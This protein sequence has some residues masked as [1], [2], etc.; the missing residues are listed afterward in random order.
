[1]R[2]ENTKT[3][4]HRVKSARFGRNRQQQTARKQQMQR[5]AEST[6]CKIHQKVCAWL[7]MLNWSRY[8]YPNPALWYAWMMTRWVCCFAVVCSLNESFTG[9][10][11]HAELH[12]VNPQWTK[13]WQLLLALSTKKARKA[14]E[15][16]TQDGSHLTMLNVPGISDRS[17]DMLGILAKLPFN[18][19]MGD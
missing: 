10:G 15:K 13:L 17:A 6:S 5:T 9:F 14:L 18:H 16:K 11:T 19:G 3:Q 7:W 12:P 8:R 1:M 4:R 2:G